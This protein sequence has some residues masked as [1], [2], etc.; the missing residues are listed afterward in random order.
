MNG[1]TLNIRMPKELYEKL[2][3]VADKKNISI[4]ALVRMICSEYFED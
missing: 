1:T 4:S 2:K 3:A